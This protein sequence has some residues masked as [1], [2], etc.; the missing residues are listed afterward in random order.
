MHVFV[1]SSSWLDTSFGG[2][3]QRYLL[4]HAHVRAIYHSAI[5]RQF[6]TAQ[7]N[8]IISIIQSAAPDDDAP[9]KFVS[10]HAP[11]LSAISDPRLRREIVITRGDLWSTGL[12]F[13][14]GPAGST[15]AGD[16]WGGKYLRAPDIYFVL[17][18]KGRGRLHRLGQI[19][20]VNEGKPTG[21]NDFFYPTREIA[22]RFGIEQRF[23]HPGL[24]KV[25]GANHFVIRKEHLSRWF[26]SVTEERSRLAGT[27]ALAYIRYGES[28]NLDQ[29]ATYKNKA[30]WYTFSV[31]RPAQLLLPCGIG[32]TFFCAVNEAGAIASNSY[33]EIR[34]RAEQELPAIWAWLNSAVGWL[35]VE[36]MG[37]SNLGGGLLKVDPIDYR[38]MNLLPASELPSDVPMLDRPVADIRREVHS[39]DRRALD[40]IV[41]DAL[42]LTH[43]EREAVYEAILRLIDERGE[44]ADSLP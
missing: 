36:L 14:D 25:R 44:K 33:T 27:G 29:R 8:T 38:Q 11:F 6:A 18:S 23:L 13:G 10:L 37:R 32:S 24:M 30:N 1:C 41:F 42:S 3:L 20:A 39:E 28:L 21:A 34:L 40:S 5:E 26:F 43:D 31:R 15:Y 22:A 16:K 35:Y 4:S 9:T 7:I 12:A 2:A 17:L 19:G